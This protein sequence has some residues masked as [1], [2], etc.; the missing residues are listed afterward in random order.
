MSYDGFISYSHAADG[1]LAPALQHGLQ[2]LAKPWNARR[3]LRV[4]RD[5][6]GLS[7][8]PHLWS[9]IEE[10]LDAS[11]WFVL[12]ASVEAAQSEWVNKEITHWLATK[13]VERMLPVVTD[14]VWEWDPVTDDFTAGSTAVP[15]ALRGALIAEPRH[16]DLRWARDETDLDLRNSRFRDAV[17]DL[18][19]PMHGVDKDEL[20][21]ED[22][23]QHRRTRRLAR[24]GVIAL[25]LLAVISVVLGVLTLASRNH[26]VSIGN[27]AKAQALAAR[28]ENELSADPEVSVLLARRALRQSPIPEAVSA[29]RQAIDASAVRVAL[30]TQ[31]ERQCGFQSGPAIAPNPA[32]DRI[33]ESLCTGEVL[34]LDARTGRTVT[35]RHLSREASAVSYDPTGSTLAVGTD[36]GIELLDPATLRTRSLLPGRGEANAIT[37]NADGTVLAATTDLGV[38]AWDIAARSPRFSLAEPQRDHTLAF[39]PD[40]HSL[41]VGTTDTPEVVDVGLGQVVRQ[42]TVPGRESS[43]SVNP[44]AIG[45]GHVVVVDNVSNTPDASA[46]VDIWNAT[47]WTR[48]GTVAPITGT[49]AA[50]VAISGDGAKVAVGNADGT[51]GVWDRATNERLVSLSGQTALLGTVAF[52]PDATTVATASND[53]TARIYRATPAARASLP[54]SVCSCGRE[55][56]WQGHTLQ[57]LLR[58]GNDVILQGWSVPGGGTPAAPTTLATNEATL[59]AVLSPR[60]RFMA[61]WNDETPTTDVTVVDTMTQRVVFTLPATSVHGVSFTEDDRRLVVA[62]RAGGLHVTDLVTG[63][64]VVGHGWTRSCNDGAGHPPAVSPDGRRVA[65][66]SF[67][68]Q[69]SVGRLDSARPTR[70]YSQRGQLSGL[71]F[72]PSGTRLALSSWDGAATVLD[73][74]TL[75]PELE[76]VGHTGGVNGVAF[77]PNG[78]YVATTSTDDTLRIWDATNGQVLQ[79]VRDPNLPSH[80]TYRADGRYVAEADNAGQIRVWDACTHCGNPSALLADSGRSVVSPLTPLEQARVAS[81]DR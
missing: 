4:F 72:D 7:T 24:T 60:G 29:L 47:S 78:R 56:A 20:E 22:V 32:G 53:G 18:A 49:E 76:L 27:T 40:G 13:S 9:A 66:W 39:S 15:G 26:A 11:D 8:N 6:T 51:G 57:A 31:S 37:F 65:I 35:R 79:I 58:A 54:G 41:V 2:R 5:E 36:R 64:T 30:P 45:G 28:S 52:G 63:R 77:S 38:T 3:A 33:A 12:L 61:R 75:R 17:A 19:A 43:G 46:Y 25:A 67:C 16:L 44:V 74:A 73:V 71:T 55:L 1:R 59:G 50:S 10:A 23:R 48:E 80:P 42:L 70:R 34:L 81:L 62:D 68:G 21:G 14:G 69:L